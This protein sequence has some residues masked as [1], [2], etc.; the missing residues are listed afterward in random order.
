MR[1]R[2]VAD[3]DRNR[4][5][6]GGARGGLHYANVK[7]FYGTLSAILFGQ[8]RN[9]PF[10]DALA[11]AAESGLVAQVGQARITVE[12]NV[13]EITLFTGFIE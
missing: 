11:Q 12:I 1:G 10:E 6:S 2:F 13:I 9:G 8:L 3:V 7:A 5:V 4:S